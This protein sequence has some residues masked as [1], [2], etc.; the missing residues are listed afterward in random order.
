M[1]EIRLPSTVI[2]HIDDDT[3][4]LSYELVEW[5]KE[6]CI[7]AI[8]WAHLKNHIDAHFE[9]EQDAVLFKMRWY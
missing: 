9:E 5:V 8:R 7:G 1:P 4:I 6:N 2:E 3:Y